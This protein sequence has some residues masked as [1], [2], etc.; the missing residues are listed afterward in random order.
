MSATFGLKLT[1]FTWAIFSFDN[2]LNRSC[3]GIKYLL[4]QNEISGYYFTNGG[5][6]YSSKHV[7]KGGMLVMLMIQN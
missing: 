1:Y 5:A 2:S 4:S 6:V 3:T 7:H